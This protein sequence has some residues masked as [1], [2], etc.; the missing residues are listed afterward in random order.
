MFIHPGGKGVGEVE[1]DGR[2]VSLILSLKRGLGV[3]GSGLASFGV[4]SLG[5]A[6]LGVASLGVA[7]LGKCSSN[8]RFFLFVK[9]FVIKRE[10]IISCDTFNLFCQLF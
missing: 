7:S 4:A 9:R 10:Y 3:D 5:V 2:A 1:V 6:S 8:V